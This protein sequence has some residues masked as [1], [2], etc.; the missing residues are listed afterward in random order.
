MNTTAAQILIPVAFLALVLAVMGAAAA[1]VTLHPSGWHW[2][3]HHRGRRPARGVLAARKRLRKRLH[4][5]LHRTCRCRRPLPSAAWWNELEVRGD[6]WPHG[7]W[8][9]VVVGFWAEQERGRHL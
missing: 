3:E 9:D 6:L 2:L 7:E 4:P 8:T 1:G 5:W